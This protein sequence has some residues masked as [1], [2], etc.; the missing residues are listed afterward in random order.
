MGNVGTAPGT[1]TVTLPG[2]LTVALSDW[3]DD[4]QWTT[5][6]LENG[7]NEELQAFAT[8]RSQAIVGGTRNNTLVDTNIKGTGLTGLNKAWEFMV[9]G[10]ALEYIR[11]TRAPSLLTGFSDLVS[12]RTA[13]ELQRRIFV[14]YN[15]NG[16]DYAQG[17]IQDFP[18]GHGLSVFTTQ[19]STELVNNGIPSP[20]DRVALVLP[21]RERELLSYFMSIVP[22][23]PLAISQ[24]A[25]DGNQPN[26]TIVDLRV[27]K[28]GLIKRTVV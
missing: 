7:D 17:L 9:Y 11:A 16:K 13:F 5:V 19:T 1:T 23:I 26:L 6:E 10:W 15:Y 25:S 2:G 27:I 22:V 18:A 3:I 12:L 14:Q 21:V 8:G 20:R 4:K 28:N 24:P